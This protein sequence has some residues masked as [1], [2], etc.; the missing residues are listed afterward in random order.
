MCKVCVYT[1]T[2]MNIVLFIMYMYGGQRATQDQSTSTLYETGSLAYFTDY[3]RLAALYLLSFL[4]PISPRTVGVIEA[5]TACLVLSGFWEFKLRSSSFKCVLPTEASPHPSSQF[6]SL[7]DIVFFV[8]FRLF[9]CF[10][11]FTYIAPELG[12]RLVCCLA[13]FYNLNFESAIHGHNSLNACHSLIPCLISA[14][15]WNPTAS[16]PPIFMSCVCV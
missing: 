13:L 7:S 4:C 15:C 14:S 9:A 3:T 16:L 8:V 1:H 11:F 2:H 6:L 12:K 5:H 10:C